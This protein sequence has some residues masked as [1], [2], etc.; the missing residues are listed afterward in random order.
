MILTITL[1]PSVDLFYSTKHFIIDHVNKMENPITMVGGKGINAARTAS[2]LG[3]KVLAATILGGKNGEILKNATA[4]ESFKLI[5]KT[6]EAET[7]NAITVMHDE[8]K[9]TEITEMGPLI[10]ATLENEFYRLLT[11]TLNQYPDIKII[12]LSGSANSH[13]TYLYNELIQYIQTFDNKK[14]HILLDISGDRLKLFLK[15]EIHADFIKPNLH[16]FSELVGKSL[17]DKEQ[18]ILYL[19]NNPELK[20]I[21]F[22]LVSCGKDGAVAKYH[23]IVYDLTIP[24]IKPVNLTGS[25][26]ATV[27]GV[28]YA[29]SQNW[30][31]EDVLK[32]AMACGISNALEEKV[33]FVSLENIKKYFEKI[34]IK[35]V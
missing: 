28:A 35:K 19:K 13:N 16:E 29:L 31:I 33:G 2:I 9:Q 20:H 34:E 25:G 15:N 6:I 26:D 22:I 27:G 10:S 21:P 4:N 18:V 7:R 30:E 12:C 14:R 24:I 8:D 11:E 23:D 17:D 3:E 32:L 5:Y 1:N